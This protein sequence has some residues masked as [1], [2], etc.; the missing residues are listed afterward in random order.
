MIPQAKRVQGL[1]ANP[2]VKTSKD[3]IVKK[4]KGVFVALQVT[5]QGG[6]N[7]LTEVDLYID[8]QNVVA[9]TYV[10]SH[11]VGL[12]RENNS[13]TILCE[14][15]INTISVQ[16]NEPLFFE[17]ELRVSINTN[18]DAGMVQIVASAVIGSSCTYPV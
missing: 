7:N 11:N 3:L 12:N 14:G 13:G 15:V 16:Y 6:S 1:I 2:A 5:K 17:K 4:G 9:M 18:S 8:G 10:A